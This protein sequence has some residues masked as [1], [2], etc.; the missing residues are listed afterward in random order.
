VSP[1]PEPTGPAE[2]G[3]VLAE[4]YRRRFPPS[5]LA[6]MTAVWAV[7]VREFFGP[8]IPVASVVLDIGAGP[9][10]FI[11]QVQAARRIAL[12][13]NPELPTLAAPGVEVIVDDDVTLRAIPDATADVVFVSNVLEHL[14]SPLEILRM[15]VAIRRVLRPGGEILVLQPNFRLCPGQYFDF[16]DHSVIVTD[17]GLVEGLEASGFDVVELKVRFLP[18]TSKSAVPRWPWAVSL[19][20]KLPPLQWLMGGQTFVRARRRE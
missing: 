11:N 5:D 1:R 10:L 19:Y 8:R 17:R 2:L 9:C 3:G 6:A 13:A 18:F 20:L 15:L 7:L 4:L 14:A 16:A 12:D